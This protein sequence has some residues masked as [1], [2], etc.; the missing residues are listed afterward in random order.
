MG[1]GYDDEATDILIAAV[2]EAKAAYPRKDRRVVIVHAQTMREEQPD[3][4]AEL[5]MS[6]LFPRATSVTE[7]TGTAISFWGGSARHVSTRCY[8]IARKKRNL[9]KDPTAQGE[10]RSERT[11]V[12]F[13]MGGML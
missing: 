9:N 8:W 12:S 1:L 5:G 6:R 4:A 7:V 11:S 13:R 3:A 2:R 10:N